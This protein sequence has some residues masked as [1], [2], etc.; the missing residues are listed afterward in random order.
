M[1]KHSADFFFLSPSPLPAASEG[2]PLKA[3]ASLKPNLP[4][5]ERSLSPIGPLPINYQTNMRVN[6]N[7]TS[8][9]KENTDQVML[10]RLLYS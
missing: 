8:G 6:F 2:L 7:E 1:E 5:L 10:S 9:A 4:P 3:E